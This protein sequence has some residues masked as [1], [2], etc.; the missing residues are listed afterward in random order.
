M[1]RGV[2]ERKQP[3]EAPRTSRRIETVR[4]DYA[5]VHWSPE[6]VEGLSWSCVACHESWAW[7]GVWEALVSIDPRARH[8]P[9][10][11]L[12]VEP[13]IVGPP[14]E[15]KKTPTCRECGRADIRLDKDGRVLSHGDAVTKARHC[16]GRGYMPRWT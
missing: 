14:P 13:P 3:E 1:P 4:G 7:T 2:Y 9:E 8:V 15:P 11:G 5:V 16:R 12:V 6:P 10:I